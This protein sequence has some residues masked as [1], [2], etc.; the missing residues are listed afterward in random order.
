M[1]RLKKHT[2]HYRVILA[3]FYLPILRLSNVDHLQITYFAALLRKL[4]RLKSFL[5]TLPEACSEMGKVLITFT[6]L[7][8]VSASG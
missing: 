6:N 7:R 4:I 2:A 1:R 5:W 3:D 8:M